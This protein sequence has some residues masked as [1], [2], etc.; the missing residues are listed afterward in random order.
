MACKYA[1]Y[2]QF[3]Y[4]SF[5]RDIFKEH[6]MMQLCN[7]RELWFNERNYCMFILYSQWLLMTWWCKESGHQQRPWYWPSSHGIF[8]FHFIKLCLGIAY[9]HWDCKGNSSF[10]SYWMNVVLKELHF[11]VVLGLYFNK[12]TIFPGIKI[13]IQYCGI[14]W[15]P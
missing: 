11:L 3:P 6:L 14:T 15:V 5:L 7:V 9:I 4:D 13:P 12:K 1:C 2:R 8:R 10:R